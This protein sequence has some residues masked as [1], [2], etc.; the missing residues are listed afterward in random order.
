MC[1]FSSLIRDPTHI[2]Y[3]EKWSLNHQEDRE[4]QSMLQLYLLNMITLSSG[5]LKLRSPHTVPLTFPCV[6]RVFGKSEV[7]LPNLILPLNTVN[8]PPEL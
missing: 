8:F 2:P 1:D 3:T 7:G 6:S 4:A 5:A